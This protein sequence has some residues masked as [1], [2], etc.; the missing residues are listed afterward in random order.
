MGRDNFLS[1]GSDYV[2]RDEERA[3]L[4][5]HLPTLSHKVARDFFDAANW[6]DA[7]SGHFLTLEGEENGRL[8]YLVKGAVAITLKGQIIGRCEGGNFVGEITALDGGTAT[9]SAMLVSSTRYFSIATADLKRLCMGNPELRLT[10]ERAM[11]LDT[12]KKL[13]ASNEALRQS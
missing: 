1:D 4:Q 9:A 5:D 13:M 11:M 10:L 2:F 12:R 6:V 7:E 3:F 8:I